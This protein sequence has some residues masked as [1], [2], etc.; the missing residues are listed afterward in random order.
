MTLRSSNKTGSYNITRQYWPPFLFL[1]SRG[2]EYL[3][4]GW[5]GMCHTRR[6]PRPKPDLGGEPVHC[7]LA[8]SSGGGEGASAHLIFLPRR[9]GLLPSYPGAS[10]NRDPLWTDGH[11]PVKTLPSLVLRIWSIIVGFS[12]ADESEFGLYPRRVL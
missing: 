6:W 12:A 2:K 11:I 10:L 1:L 4:W 7:L 3:G 9:R 5:G 8:S